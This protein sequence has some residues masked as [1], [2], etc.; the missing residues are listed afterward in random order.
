MSHLHARNPM[1]PR[2]LA[3]TIR[4][5]SDW[6]ESGNKGYF[7]SFR[8]THFCHIRRKPAVVRNILGHA[9]IDVTQNVYAKS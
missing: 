8:T 9:N 6:A 4:R 3:A 2:M 1:C 5:D 7:R